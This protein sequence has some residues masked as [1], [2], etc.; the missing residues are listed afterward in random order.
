M[1][2]NSQDQICLVSREAEIVKEPWYAVCLSYILP[3]LGLIYAQKIAPGILMLCI[4][5]LLIVFA[6]CVV[7]M[8]GM[9]ILALP[10]IALAIFSVWLVNIVIA[11]RVSKTYNPAEAEKERRASKDPWLSVFLTMIIPG[12]G[13]FYIG[14]RGIGAVLI[15]IFLADIIIVPDNIYFKL[16]WILASALFIFMSYKSAPVNREKAY[17][18]IG[19]L[20]TLFVL[21]AIVSTSSGPLI[22]NFLFETALAEGNS[23]TPA[24]YPNDRF[25]MSKFNRDTLQRGD[26]IVFNME[27]GGKDTPNLPD[28]RKISYLKRVVALEGETVE[29]KGGKLLINGIEL[30]DPRFMY[31]NLASMGDI[32]KVGNPY[33]VPENT[34]FVLGDNPGNS[35]DSRRLGAIPKSNIHGKIVKRIFPIDRLGQVQ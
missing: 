21:G 11:Y 1:E 4:E 35:L 16:I 20:C 27:N 19:V 33:M 2:N 5:I 22:R 15:L 3:G 24:I 6:G 17:G 25:I 28:S 8:P 12:I 9:N 31:N 14:K 30:A 34:V 23:M 7:L 29:I 18:K 13:H 32:A 10:F 26:I